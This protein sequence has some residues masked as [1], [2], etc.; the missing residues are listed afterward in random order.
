MTKNWGFYDPET[1][2]EALSFSVETKVPLSRSTPIK[3]DL[4]KNSL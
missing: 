4:L 3:V 2:K 1:C